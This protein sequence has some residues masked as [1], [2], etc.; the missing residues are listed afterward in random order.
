MTSE[1]APIV[2]AEELDQIARLL[3]RYC[4][5][6]A[7]GLEAVLCPLLVPIETL[8]KKITKLKGQTHYRASFTVEITPENQSVLQIGRTGK[9]VPG[10]YLEGAAWL[11]IAKGRIIRL[12][13]AGGT[14]Y[15][16]V[17]TG[18]KRGNLEEAL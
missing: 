6:T 17:Y 10:K 18:G 3:K 13:E 4:G 14:A 11:E 16:E 1:V 12:D 9:F 8:D 5:A 15:G 7:E 2:K